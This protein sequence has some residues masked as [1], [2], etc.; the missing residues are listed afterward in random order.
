ML[1]QLF[2]NF[3]M[4]DCESIDSLFSRFAD[5]V[6]PLQSLGK[7]ITDEEQVTKLLYSLRGPKWIQKRQIVEAT[8]NL[9]LMTFEGLMGNLKACEVQMIADN[10]GPLNVESKLEAKKPKEEKNIA[11]K[12]WK[13]RYKESKH[14]RFMESSDSE[15]EDVEVLVKNFTRSL[16]K[17][18]G[19]SSKKE[20]KDKGKFRCYRCNEPGHIKT[21][22]PLSKKEGG[23]ASKGKDHVKPKFRRDFKNGMLATWSDDEDDVEGQHPSDDDNDEGFKSGAYIST[24]ENEERMANHEFKN[25]MCFMALGESEVTSTP[26]DNMMMMRMIYFMSMVFHFLL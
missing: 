21:E 19:K 7:S 9:A 10:E 6:N 4:N 23:E 3:K 5:I 8:Q 2:E 14:R 11:F 25:G 18:M 20:D 16:M 24:K 22:C 17:I 12:A 13:G 26:I 15:D 1:T